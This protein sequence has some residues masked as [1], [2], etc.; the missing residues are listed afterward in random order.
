MS[1]ASLVR[2]SNY[3]VE[4]VQCDME[5][6][7]GPV[8]RILKTG[9]GRDSLRKGGPLSP[10][11]PVSG[12]IWSKKVRF[13]RVSPNSRK[14]QLRSWV[15]RIDVDNRGGQ[16]VLNAIDRHR[17][18]RPRRISCWYYLSKLARGMFGKKGRTTALHF[19][20]SKPPKIVGKPVSR[21]GK[22]EICFRPSSTPF[23]KVL[24]T[25][26]L[27]RASC[28]SCEDDH[29]YPRELYI[30]VAK[31]GCPCVFPRLRC[32]RIYLLHV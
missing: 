32:F 4:S 19:E 18:R 8:D 27:R 9:F 15:Y 20:K 11:D 5:V 16:L 28:A 24:S 23:E 30:K 26:Q 1:C 14:I 2:W 13:V 3:A 17:R 6:P 7:S 22:S 12:C 10:C 25:I 21:R 29:S 31:W